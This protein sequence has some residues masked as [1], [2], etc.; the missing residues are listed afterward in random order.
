MREISAHM[1]NETQNRYS[2]V[3]TCTILARKHH[4]GLTAVMGDDNVKLASCYIK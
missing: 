4:Q 1:I 3:S 2:C